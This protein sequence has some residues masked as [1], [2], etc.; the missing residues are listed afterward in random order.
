[1]RAQ[2]MSVG[3]LAASANIKGG[4]LKETTRGHRAI[5]ISPALERYAAPVGNIKNAR[6]AKW[7]YCQINERLRRKIRSADAGG[8]G[9]AQ[10][11]LSPIYQ[12]AQAN[13]AHIL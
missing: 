9:D 13:S 4:G 6:R 3:T 10:K 1:M 7:T 12:T 2:S 5:S 8:Q 11:R